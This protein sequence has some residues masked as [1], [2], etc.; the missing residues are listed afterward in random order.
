MEDQKPE[1]YLRIVG[2]KTWTHERIKEYS[3][4]L[5]QEWLDDCEPDERYS[6]HQNGH[7]RIKSLFDLCRLIDLFVTKDGL[8]DYMDDITLEGNLKSLVAPAGIFIGRELI[9][10]TGEYKD[11]IEGYINFKLINA[12][13]DAYK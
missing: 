10:G 11:V 12:I 5:A 8:N 2:P 3:N 6:G 1:F 7:I 9:K 13:K 4:K